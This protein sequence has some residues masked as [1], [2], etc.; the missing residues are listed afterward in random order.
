MACKIERDK[1]K[2]YEGSPSDS[3]NSSMG[4]NWACRFAGERKRVIFRPFDTIDTIYLSILAHVV[5][6][7]RYLLTRVS[8]LHTIEISNNAEIDS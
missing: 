1:R 4:E 7:V 6:D 3:A 2:R 8:K 5:R